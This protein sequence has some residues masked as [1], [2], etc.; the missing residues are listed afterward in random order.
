MFENTYIKQRIQKADSL[1]DENLNPYRNDCIVDMSNAEFL[2]TYGFLK[3]EKDLDS[4]DSLLKNDKLDSSASLANDGGGQNDGGSHNDMLYHQ[5]DTLYYRNDEERLKQ[6]T[7]TTPKQESTAE[8]EN[9]RIWVKGR[10]KFLRLMG[11][12]SFIK[13][14]DESAILQIYFSQN[15]LGDLFKILKKHLEVGDIEI[16]SLDIGRDMWI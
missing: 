12:A 14:E 3:S 8:L 1:R 2:Q 16:L 9:K 11:K 10:V 15:E 13:I 7:Q 5:N 4:K 6:T